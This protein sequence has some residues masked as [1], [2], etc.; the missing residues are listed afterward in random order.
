M[1][2]KT[3]CPS[4]DCK[5]KRSSSRASSFTCPAVLLPAFVGRTPAVTA[6]AT[7]ATETTSCN[8]RK[9][10]C[11]LFFRRW[12]RRIK[13]HHDRE[14][15]LR[16]TWNASCDAMLEE[17]AVD[18]ATPKNYLNSIASTAGE[19]YAFYTL[20]ETKSKVDVLATVP[21]SRGI[22]TRFFPRD[23][24]LI[25]KCEIKRRRMDVLFSIREWEREREK[26][27][28]T[29]SFRY[30][31]VVLYTVHVDIAYKTSLYVYIN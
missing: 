25:G 24:F 11:L 26:I 17:C 15:D 27:I 8:T 5:W 10:F 21:F 7:D 22:Y 14:T 20:F 30:S 29:A 9:R 16:Q 31:Y 19:S 18:T 2:P 4:G 12:Q 23:I 13:Y 1:C 3:Y 28:L 6:T